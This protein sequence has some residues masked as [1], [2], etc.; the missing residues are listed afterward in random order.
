MSTLL[1]GQQLKKHYKIQNSP[2][3]WFR[4]ATPKAQESVIH[5]L[6]NVSFS[7]K[8][9]QTLAIVGES[10]SGK[11]TLARLITQ[12]EPLSSGEIWFK[13]QA[14]SSLTAQER[15]AWQH[16]I[17]MIFQNPFASLNPRRTIAAQLEEPLK[18]NTS[19]N[20]KQRSKLVIE[21]LQQV[22]LFA[23]HSKRYPHMFSGGQRQRI[24]IARSL[25]LEPD[26]IVADEPVSALD[27]SVQAQV[28]NLMVELKASLGLSY[29]FI[30]HD[31]SVVQHIADDI[32]VM[33]LGEII[34]SSPKDS[35]FNNPKHPYTRLLLESRPKIR[36]SALHRSD[37]YSQAHIQHRPHDQTHPASNDSFISYQE[38]PAANHPPSG[39]AFHLRCPWADRHCREKKPEL[40]R[41]SDSEKVACFKYAEI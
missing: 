26:I 11:S 30:S 6:D 32:L 13:G 24:A 8:T 33:Y 1:V 4:F 37:R 21:K 2:S 41:V 17:A 9:Q 20:P 34:E 3:A 16:N 36:T 31:L 38:Q 40:E 25:M 35:L 39:C 27:V 23:E 22:G 18:F 12:I 14:L 29:V 28:L 5:A 10:G 15:R 19:L 7:L